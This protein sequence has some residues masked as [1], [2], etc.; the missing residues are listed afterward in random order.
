MIAANRVDYFTEV[1]KALIRSILYFD[2]FNYP[3][4]ASEARAFAP[5]SI[6]RDCEHLLD[7]LVLQGILF[8]HSGFYSLRNDAGLVTKR[9]DG[10]RLAEQRMKTARKFSNL[11]ASFPFVRAV[12]LSGSISKNFMDEN[13]DI[14]YFIVTEAKRLW[15][16]RT[17]L[18]VF[19]RIF[20]FNS[21]RNFCVN[22]F[23][24]TDN[25]AIPDRNI[26][27]A[28]EFATLR[29]MYGSLAISKL[30]NANSWVR[31]S[32]PQQPLDTTKPSNQDFYL[33]KVLEFIAEI[34]PLNWINT[35]LM[36]FS[37]SRWKRRYQKQYQAEDF[38]VAFR[39][40]EGISKCHPRFFQKR[41]LSQLEGKIRTFQFQHSINLAV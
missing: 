33:K 14:D 20:L 24:D 35:W 21:L 34:A 25:L 29:P 15:I 28:T 40:K 23:V 16:V 5:F 22:Y 12:M 36:K 37:M 31:E 27:T 18:V 1:D 10:N 6:D 19:R 3:I 17:A 8:K 30:Q 38:E 7:N 11:I 13:S 32:L 26:F 41:A 4:T 39:C 2:I 9:L